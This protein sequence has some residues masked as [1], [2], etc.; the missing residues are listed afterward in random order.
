MAVVLVVAAGYLLWSLS[1]LS[2]VFPI[3]ARLFKHTGGGPVEEPPRVEQALRGGGS[4]FLSFS[5]GAHAPRPGCVCRRVLR[6][7]VVLSK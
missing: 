3:F 4:S 5:R 7:S 1:F 6:Y 2:V